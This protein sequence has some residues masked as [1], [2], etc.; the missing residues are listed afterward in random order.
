[1]G[2]VPPAMAVVIFFAM[3]PKPNCVLWTGMSGWAV[4]KASSMWFI[5]AVSVPPKMCQYSMPAAALLPDAAGAAVEAALV[6]ALTAA[7]L[8][9]VAAVLLATLVVATTAV[10]AAALLAGV[11]AAAEM[12][13]DVTAAVEEV[14]AVAAPPQALN[15]MPASTTNPDPAILRTTVRR[16]QR[17][18]AIASYFL[19]RPRGVFSLTRARAQAGPSHRSAVPSLLASWNVP[20]G[21]LRNA[22]QLVK[23]RSQR[24]S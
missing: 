23:T 20:R 6:A 3:F 19:P 4:T 11:L 13:A 5:V 10:V 8:A 15:A 2:G 12:A 14:V 18:T 21:T 17:W 7:A 1:L 16:D 9:E 24:G 22:G